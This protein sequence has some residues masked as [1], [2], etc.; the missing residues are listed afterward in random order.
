MN[1]KNRY[2]AT[3]TITE[4]G[5]LTF[6]SQTIFY[7]FSAKVKQRVFIWI[8]ICEI[9]LHTWITREADFCGKGTTNY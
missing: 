7:F 6:N 8:Y 4:L 9:N 3:E 1:C 2:T 5:H